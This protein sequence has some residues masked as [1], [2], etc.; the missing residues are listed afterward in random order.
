MTK[1][2]L[3]CT[4]C[5]RINKLDLGYNLYEFKR[6]YVFCEHCNKNTFHEIIGH[7]EERSSDQR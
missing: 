4:S 1:W 7:E 6:I 2:L 5:G 3:K